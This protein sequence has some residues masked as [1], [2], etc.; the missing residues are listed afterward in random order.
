ME[1]RMPCWSRSPV[2]PWWCSSASTRRFD[3][4]D[5]RFEALERRVD[6]RFRDLRTIHDRDFRLTR[7]G[8]IAVALGLA[9]L[10]THGFYWF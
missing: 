5:R 3:A 8:L 4:S 2:R 7:A 10:L 1:P 9:A 6:E